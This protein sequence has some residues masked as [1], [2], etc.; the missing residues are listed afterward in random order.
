MVARLSD[1]VTRVKYSG[2]DYATIEDEL[3]TR[4]QV[5]FAASYNDFAI[6]SLGIM[7]IDLFSYGLDTLSFYLDRRATDMYMA[8]A[9]TRKSVSRLARQLGYKMAPATASSID[10]TISPKVTQSFSIP[11]AVGFQLKGQDSSTWEAGQ[12]YTWPPSNNTPQVITFSQVQTQQATFTSDGTSNQVFKIAGVPSNEFVVGPGSDGVSQVTV[13]INNENWVENDLLTFGA[14]N[15]FEI[16]YHDAPATLRFGDSVAGNTPPAGTQISVT[17]KT[18]R[19]VAGRVTAGQT[20]SIPR[21]LVTNFTTIDLNVTTPNGSNGGSDP[22]TIEKAKATAPNF[23]RARGVNITKSDYNTR[24]GAFVDSVFGAIAVASAVTVRGASTDAYLQT[25]V[26]SINSNSA[27][28]VTSVNNN[29]AIIISDIATAVATVNSTKTANDASLAGLNAVLSDV[30]TQVT[31]CRDAQVASAM[32]GTFINQIGTSAFSLSSAVAA[33][34]AGTDGLSSPTRLALNNLI[35][36]IQSS[37]TN[38]T[39]QSITISS[40]VGLISTAID[41]AKIDATTA[42]ASQAIMGTNITAVLAQLATVSS[43]V[44][45]MQ[46]SVL[47]I[48]DTTA[49]LG[50]QVIDHVDSFLSS[51]CQANLVEVPILTFDADGFYVPP[52]IAL[53]KSLQSYLDQNKEITQVIKVFAATDQLIPVNMTVTV[54]VLAGFSQPSIASQI[55]TIILTVLRKRP[56]GRSLRLAEL[57]W[58]IDVK[59]S[60]IAGMDFVDIAITSPISKLDGS[61]NVIIASNEVV[62]RGTIT[63]NTQ[64]VVSNI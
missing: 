23:F 4:L 18:S 5:K 61:G 34:A 8:T 30:S 57:Y 3:L 13:R 62:T 51:D 20:M 39:G 43:A 55:N 31:N 47:S 56:F 24:A 25:L 1:S 36:S 53:V 54:G 11:L 27:S 40:D 7:I 59:N 38:A 46:S 12:S 58:A 63:V 29:S 21:P 42:V 14:T 41:N 52:T 26:N 45:L 50:Q 9:R 60:G 17:Y 16:G 49:L 37:S 2:L 19:G 28:F 32:I 35:A 48:N 6:A 44:V 33:I 64:L 22:E 10:V 15:Q